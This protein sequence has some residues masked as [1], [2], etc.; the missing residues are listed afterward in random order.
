MIN[1][2]LI[3]THSEFSIF[4]RKDPHFY[5]IIVKAE[6]VTPQI[7]S[8]KYRVMF[9]IPQKHSIT[10]SVLI[11]SSN[12]FNDFFLKLMPTIQTPV[13]FFFLK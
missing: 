13:F 1:S 11:P 6:N 4:F 7:H 10:Y 3:T 12:S 2:W 9:K 8:S 5:F